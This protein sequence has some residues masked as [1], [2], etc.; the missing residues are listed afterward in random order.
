[1]PLGKPAGVRCVQLT[2]D[3]RCL[4]LAAPDRPLVCIR[5]RPNDEMCGNTADQA[6]AWLLA[7]EYATR[8]NTPN[9]P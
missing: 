6:Y 7:L 5:L 1:M 2:V 3:N 4:L 8:P 9:P